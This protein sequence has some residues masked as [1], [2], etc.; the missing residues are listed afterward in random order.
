[1]LNELTRVLDY[2]DMPSNFN[3]LSSINGC[4]LVAGAY[5]GQGAWHS[6]IKIATMSGIEVRERMLTDE[7][8]DPKGSY[9]NS[10]IAH[11]AKRITLK[12]YR[13]RC[14]MSSLW[15]MKNSDHLH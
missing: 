13:K 11:I 10:Q 3:C 14:P 12:F 7:N 5:Q 4:T 1:M 2:T 9:M 8:F 15:H 6:W